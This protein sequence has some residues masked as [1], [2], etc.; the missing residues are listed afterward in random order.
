MPI[1]LLEDFFEKHKNNFPFFHIH[2]SPRPFQQPSFF[3]DVY[4]EEL[5][6]VQQIHTISQKHFSADSFHK[7]SPIIYKFNQASN[8]RIKPSINF[9]KAVTFELIKPNIPNE[10]ISKQLI[11]CFY[12]YFSEVKR[13]KSMYGLY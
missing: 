8:L 9:T 5:F 6:S 11:K 7:N 4:F 3:V 1:I 13:I 12:E 2:H 10:D